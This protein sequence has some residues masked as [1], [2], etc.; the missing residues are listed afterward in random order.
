M[1][2]ATAS[3]T[4]GLGNTSATINPGR[5]VT[6]SAMRKESTIVPA[7][8]AHAPFDRRHAPAIAFAPL[9]SSPTNT[10]TK[11]ASLGRNT[12]NIVRG[13]NP[14]RALESADSVALAM[15]SSTMRKGSAKRTRTTKIHRSERTPMIV[16]PISAE[17]LSGS[18]YV[19]RRPRW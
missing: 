4:S 15:P 17:P 9:E 3:P 19:A 16:R 10:L 7:E 2:R 12:R 6:A 11:V 5:I 1:V 13:T 8:V 14:R 18:E